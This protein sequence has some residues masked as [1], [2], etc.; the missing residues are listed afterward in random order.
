MKYWS[1]ITLFCEKRRPH[2]NRD[3]KLAQLSRKLVS[4]T[5][6][7]CDWQISIKYSR[8]SCNN[9]IN[10]A[11]ECSSSLCSVARRGAKYLSKNDQEWAWKQ[12]RGLPVFS[13]NAWNPR[14]LSSS[15]S[16]TGSE[17][18]GWRTDRYLSSS[19]GKQQC[20]TLY[21]LKIQK[22]CNFFIYFLHR[23]LAQKYQHALLK[24]LQRQRHLWTSLVR[25]SKA[26]G[27]V[28]R[29]WACETLVTTVNSIQQTL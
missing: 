18:K 7:W 24:D 9:T 17:R 1:E 27:L 19:P 2:S 15:H 16:A 21:G 22:L 29:S 14:T 12:E 13:G 6:E 4:Q 20:A 3:M 5:T 28:H 26:G 11:L 10:R 8:N 25:G 23:W